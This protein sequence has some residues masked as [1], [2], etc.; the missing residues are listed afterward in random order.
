MNG[1]AG[2]QEKMLI[3]LFPDLTAKDLENKLKFYMLLKMTFQSK[4]AERQFLT[5]AVFRYF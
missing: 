4:N 1:A 5:I 2:H 3:T